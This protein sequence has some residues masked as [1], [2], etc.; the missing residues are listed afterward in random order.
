MQQVKPEVS[1][2]SKEKS[3]WGIKRG[4]TNI[5]R[6]RNVGKIGM[7]DNAVKLSPAQQ[8]TNPVALRSVPAPDNE[9][10]ALRIKDDGESPVA[11]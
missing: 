3:V 6:T 10:E 8:R 7:F 5:H 11:S 1:I 4:P 2:P 9:N